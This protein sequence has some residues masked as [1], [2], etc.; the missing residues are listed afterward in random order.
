MLETCHI[1][2]EIDMRLPRLPLFLRGDRQMF[3]PNLVGD[4]L[5]LIGTRSCTY[6]DSRQAGHLQ[7][8]CECFKAAHII[9]NILK[10]FFKRFYLFILERH[11]ERQRHRQ[12]EKQAP[13]REP[14]VGLNPRTL[15]S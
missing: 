6:M 3:G 15:G 4:V 5:L 14:N 8:F 2:A 11:R 1:A 13:C 12:R 10:G 9:T 7:F